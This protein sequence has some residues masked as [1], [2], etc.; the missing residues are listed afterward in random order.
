MGETIKIKSTAADGFAFSAYHA[1]P[2][3]ERKGGVI[4]IQEIFGL[5]EHVRRDGDRWASQGYERPWRRRCS[6]VGRRGSSPL[7]TRPAWPPV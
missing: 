7:T 2:S 4:V 3:G 6:T 5:D 1:A